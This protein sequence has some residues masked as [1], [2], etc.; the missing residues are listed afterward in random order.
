M[1]AAALIRKA[2]V[3]A[4]DAGLSYQQIA[5]AVGCCKRTAEIVVGRLHAEGHLIV[6]EAAE[7]RIKVWSLKP[8]ASERAVT[9]EAEKMAAEEEAKRR[10]RLRIFELWCTSDLTQEE[11]AERVGSNLTEVGQTIRGTLGLKPG[12]RLPPTTKYVDLTGGTSPGRGSIH[13]RATRGG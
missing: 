13:S 7:K 2:L 12:E 1:R 9:Q 8:G 6:R 3:E 4:G 10:R 11:I 5:D